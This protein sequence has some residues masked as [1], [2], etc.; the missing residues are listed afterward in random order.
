MQSLSLITSWPL[1][2]RRLNVRFGVFA[3]FQGFYLITD[4]IKDLIAQVKKH[5]IK[6]SP[7]QRQPWGLL[8]KVKLPGGG[9]LKVYQPLHVR[10]K[11]A[12]G[13]RGR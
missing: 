13:V 9:S 4:D 10:P 5:K 3:P 12:K 2:L 11:T 8:T 1:S 6:C 7:V